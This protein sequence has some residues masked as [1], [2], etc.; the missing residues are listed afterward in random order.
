M[1]RGR[2]GGEGGTALLEMERGEWEERGQQRGRW[3]RGGRVSGGGREEKD[4]EG[5]MRLRLFF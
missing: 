2:R 4:R 1:R 3:R 5:K